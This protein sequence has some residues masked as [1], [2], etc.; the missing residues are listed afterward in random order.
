MTSRNPELSPYLTLRV[1]SIN[2]RF[3]MASHW[4]VWRRGRERDE[5]LEPPFFVPRRET[6]CPKTR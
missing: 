6:A 5:S 3:T 1:G 4:S 2:L